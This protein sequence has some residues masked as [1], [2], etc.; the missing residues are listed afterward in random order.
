MDRNTAAFLTQNSRV[1]P[2]LRPLKYS[3]LQTKDEAAEQE[4]EMDQEYDAM[5]ED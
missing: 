2:A 1:I 4:Q 3:K 5:M